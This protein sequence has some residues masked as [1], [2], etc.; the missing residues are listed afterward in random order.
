MLRSNDPRCTRIFQSA[1]SLLLAGAL[2][3]FA[4]PAAAKKQK[5]KADTT[6]QVATPEDAPPRD[7]GDESFGGD[8]S[9]NAGTYTLR[10]LI[11]TRYVR[12]A[13]DIGTELEE[14]LDPEFRAHMKY[15]DLMREGAR[16]N[17]GLRL[18]RVFLRATAN[19]VRSFGLKMLVDFGELVRK[20]QKKALKLAFGELRPNK[21]ITVTTGLFKIP[22]SLL[23]LLP[24]ADFEF[25]DV[26]PTDNLIKDLGI[27]GRDV[28]VMVD[29]APLRKGQWLHLQ[30]GIFNGDNDNAQRHVN[31]AIVAGRITSRPVSALRLG[32]DCAYRTQA[33]SDTNA[34]NTFE[35][36]AEGGACSADASL[37]LSHHLSLRG[38]WLAGKRTDTPTLLPLGRGTHNFMAAWLA[39]VYRLKLTDRMALMPAF[40]AE[41]LDQDQPANVGQ[42]TYL[43]A[44]MN[45][46]FSPSARLLFDLSRSNV[47]VG[48][49]DAS[50]S[51]IYA[52]S[53]TIGVVQLQFKL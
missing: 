12:T 5:R 2:L 38:E 33:V 37:S 3:A 52:P 14:R 43:T 1:F 25:A 26:G 7:T 9:T 46:E 18:E 17:D 31:P 50:T 30:A 45:L 48:T 8:D 42:I 21:S 28:G 19:P 51:T 47:Q 4:P 40:R 44:A 6:Q 15:I 53:A 36:Y 29:V 23:E 20:N 22:F 32:V 49:R 10:T 24:I 41:W 13:P 16:N 39:V 27:A 35:K 34:G 11:Q